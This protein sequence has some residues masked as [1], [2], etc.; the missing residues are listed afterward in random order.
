MEND[1][2]LFYTARED[3][4]HLLQQ[5]LSA[6]DVDCEDE[7]VP[8]EGG[9]AAGSSGGPGGRYGSKRSGGLSSMSGGDDGVYYE[10][11]R[12]NI[13]NVHPLFKKFRG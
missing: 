1:K 8:G 13:H 4:G 9:N 12:K 7:R 5:V 10:F 2:D 3:Q 6:S 11:K